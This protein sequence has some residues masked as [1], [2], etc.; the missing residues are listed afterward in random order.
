MDLT[1]LAAEVARFFFMKA[2]EGAITKLGEDSLS[3]LYKLKGIIQ[4]W[5]QEKAI[6]KE[7]AENP[8]V[9][10]AEILEEF[11]KNG[12]NS[13]KKKVE[14]LVEDLRQVESNNVNANQT[15]QFGSNQAIGSL[16]GDAIGRDKN[17]NFFR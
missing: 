7:A 2:S 3:K 9:L 5:L 4:D 17:Q 16:Q 15:N 1:L 11:S 12:N 13:F 8:E 10:Q 14:D 6:R